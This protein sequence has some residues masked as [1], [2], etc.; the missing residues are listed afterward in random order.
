[1]YSPPC[2]RSFL[3]LPRLRHLVPPRKIPFLRRDAPLLLL[4]LGLRP[5]SIRTDRSRS[6]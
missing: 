1:M 3:S 4:L 2:C 5:L 6:V